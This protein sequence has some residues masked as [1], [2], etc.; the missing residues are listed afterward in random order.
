M[1]VK[2]EFSDWMHKPKTSLKVSIINGDI[3]KVKADV[4][5]NAANHSLLGGGGVDGVIHRAAGPQLLK[6]CK[7]LNGCETGEAKMTKAYNLNAKIIIHTVGPIY[8]KDDINL[9]KKCYVNSLRIAEINLYKTIAFPAISTGV[10]GV[11]IEESAK[12]VK[13]VLDSYK[14]IDSMEV[15]L[16]LFSKS[17]FEAYKKMFWATAHQSQT[18]FCLMRH[19]C[20]IYIAPQHGRS[21][22]RF[23]IPHSIISAASS[24]FYIFRPKFITY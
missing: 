7:E 20:I 17:D 9:L 4:I 21:M 18:H 11:P 5:V 19:F 8:E 1:R 6:E 24:H 22:L 16:V 13:E 3:T 12:I 15:I 10:Y 23:C 14:T 2:D